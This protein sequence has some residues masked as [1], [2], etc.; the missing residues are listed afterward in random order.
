MNRVRIMKILSIS[1]LA[2]GCTICVH[3]ARSQQ[4][5]SSNHSGANFPRSYS[6]ATGRSAGRAS[7]FRGGST[8]GAG[9]DSFSGSGK[10]TEGIW[11]D[12]SSLG[13]TSLTGRGAIPSP[14]PETSVRL[15][16]GINPALS[17]SG[18][19]GGGGSVGFRPTIP[20]NSA[21]QARIR[22]PLSGNS[23]VSRS[24]GHKPSFAGSRG[25]GFAPIGTADERPTITGSAQALSTMPKSNKAKGNGVRQG[26]L[27]I[28]RKKLLRRQP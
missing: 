23:S 24:Y 20:R 25:R 8:W 1:I 12:G 9:K 2:S 14:P 17:I 15:P 7:G 10:R 26:L 4:T 16:R 5:A 28:P 21:S 27:S 18:R 19:T 6:T 13:A 22:K 11:T 3:P